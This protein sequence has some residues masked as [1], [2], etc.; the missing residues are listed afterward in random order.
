[1]L[2][3]FMK[4]KTCRTYSMFCPKCYKI[5]DPVNRYKMMP[6]LVC[7]ECGIRHEP[8]FGELKRVRA[9]CEMRTYEMKAIDVAKV[10]KNTVKFSTVDYFPQLIRVEYGDTEF[11]VNRDDVKTMLSEIQLLK[12]EEQK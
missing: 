7:K 3:D 8:K 12:E 2:L 5:M 11:I 6:D 9:S 4:M 1:M 10:G